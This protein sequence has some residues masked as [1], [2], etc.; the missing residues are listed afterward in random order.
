[1]ALSFGLLL[2]PALT[3]WTVALFRIARTS[4]SKVI[5]LKAA[6]IGIGLAGWSVF[7]VA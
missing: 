1:M 6:L 2:L 7:L 4:R 3:A 5:S